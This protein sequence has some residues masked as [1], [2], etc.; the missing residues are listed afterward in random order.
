MEAPGVI[1]QQTEPTDWVSSMVTGGGRGGSHGG[2]G[3]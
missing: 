1:V 3:A 2:R